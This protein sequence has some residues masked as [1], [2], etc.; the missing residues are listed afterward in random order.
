MEESP[1]NLYLDL[2]REKVK[3]QTRWDQSSFLYSVSHESTVSRLKIQNL[4]ENF[5]LT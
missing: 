2:G 3:G 1:K 5:F 4:S